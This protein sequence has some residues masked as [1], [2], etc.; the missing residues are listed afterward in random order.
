MRDFNVITTGKDEWLTPPYIPASLGRFDLDPCQPI[1][2]PYT[3]ATKGY[4]VNDDGFTKLWAGRVWLNPPYGK[5]TFRWVGKLAE[6]GNG[7]A[8]IFS[9]TETKGF[10]AHVLGKAD[11]LFFF[12]GRLKFFHVSGEQGQSAPA[13]SCLVAYGQDNVKAIEKA[14]ENGEIAGK[15]IIL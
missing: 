8:L 14:W 4:N 9:R 7:I 3:H 15:L 11:A 1:C 12:K 2:P 6:Y 5:E 10:H 13:P